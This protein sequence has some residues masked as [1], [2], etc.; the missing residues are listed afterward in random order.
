[1]LNR[2]TS[3]EVA[4]A[5]R[6]LLDE[7]GDWSAG[8]G[9]IYRQLARALGGAVDRGVLAPGSRLPSE[10]ALAARLQV[11][12]GTVL[13]AYEQLTG[14][15]LIE[16]RHGSGTYVAGPPATGARPTLPPD[17]EGSALVHH[18]A[19]AGTA[20]GVDLIDLSLSVTHDPGQLDLPAIDPAE[21][22]ATEP[23]TGYA[24]WGLPALRAAL[25]DHVTSWGLPSSA[26]HIVVTT[27]AQQAIAA[28][29]ACW[30]RPGDVVVCEDPTYPGALAAFRQAGARVVGVPVDRVGV[31]VGELAAAIDRWSP[32]L[33]YLQPDAHSPTGAVLPEGRRRAVAELL[34]RARVPLVEDLA[35]R[36]TV[37]RRTPPAPIAARLRDASAAVVG[38]LS[39]PWWGGLRV[40][41]VRAPEPLAGRF[42]RVKATMDLGSPVP[43]QL[44]ALALLRDGDPAAAL[45]RRRHEL[46]D[47]AAV[48]GGGLRQKLPAWRWREPHGGLSLWV[49][50]P[51]DASAFVRRA[52]EE[53]VVVAPPGPL[54]PSAGYRDHVRL[55]F[56]LPAD[57]LVEAVAR[58]ARAWS[59]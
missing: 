16:R 7:L 19:D 20:S 51:G 15:G 47:R 10:R 40:G 48:L 36:D 55:S 44:L 59:R 9:P 52:R 24:P 18:L 22:R 54:S 31:V 3:G 4:R 43:S 49:S 25:A 30:L 5:H 12:R 14:D 35:L 46:R 13:A 6:G 29:A 57:L 37:W 33:V 8:A 28:A 2:S 17:R 58:L 45:A 56:D 11:S 21:L 27:G 32:A 38:S 26:A 41:F 39:K 42:A 53:G 1:M 23:S 50:L 34:G